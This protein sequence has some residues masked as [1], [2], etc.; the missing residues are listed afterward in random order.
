MRRCDFHLKKKKNLSHGE[1]LRHDVRGHHF[2]R[3]QQLDC[4]KDDKGWSKGW[5]VD[6]QWDR[7][8]PRTIS[9]VVLEG[10]GPLETRKRSQSRS[11]DL[12]QNICPVGR[13]LG[14]VTLTKASQN[15][16]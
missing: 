4:L 14:T 2:H 8:G 10:V 5:E 9:E 6:L 7:M 12:H 1:F 13:D 16:T 3:H 11:E 15:S